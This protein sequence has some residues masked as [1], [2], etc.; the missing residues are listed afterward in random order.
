MYAFYL[1]QHAMSL[2]FTGLEAS[3]DECPPFLVL[4]LPHGRDAVTPESSLTQLLD[5]K[6][7]DGVMSHLLLIHEWRF[8]SGAP[9]LIGGGSLPLTAVAK[10]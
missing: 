3:C 7:D 2:N 4:G 6:E 1:T 9:L 8:S 10:A 5:V